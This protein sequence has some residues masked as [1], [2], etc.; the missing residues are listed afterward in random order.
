MSADLLVVG[1]G[2]PG[3]KYSNTRHNVGRWVVEELLRRH[4]QSLDITRELK[5]EIATLDLQG[6][7][8]V[9]AVLSTYMNNSGVAVARLVKRFTLK[10]IKRLVVLHDD[11]DLPVGSIKVKSGGG[12]AGH[13]GLKSIKDHLQAGDFTRVRIGIGRPSPFPRKH[14]AKQQIVDYVLSSPD[15]SELEALS[16]AVSRAADAVRFFSH[17]NLDSTMNLFN[18]RSDC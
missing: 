10:S 7:I 14:E 12:M 16:Q 9:V 8:I 18:S 11:L 15:E 3:S 17:N 5:A 13:R 2:N 1:L 6:Q 4:G